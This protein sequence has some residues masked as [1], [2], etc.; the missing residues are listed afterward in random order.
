MYYKLV[1]SLLT[2]QEC[3]LVADI[4]LEK[5]DSGQWLTDSCELAKGFYSI[6]PDTIIDRLLP[7]VSDFAQ[8]KVNYNFDY[9]RIYPESQ[10]L[11]KHRD[12]TGCEYSV[13]VCIK[14]TTH[15][16][17]FWII[18]PESQKPESF[19]MLPGDGLIYRGTEVL[20]WREPNPH[21]DVFQAFIHFC[22]D[23]TFAEIV[24]YEPRHVRRKQQAEAIVTR[25]KLKAMF[26]RPVRK[27][28]SQKPDK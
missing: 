6:M 9:A 19:E 18:N 5:V 12:R 8:C 10:G 23:E 28:D 17:P 7:E 11:I 26:G 13:T 25:N 14:N 21:S 16:F 22:D 15:S 3:Q 4:M 27:Q 24:D 1:K 20:H 2:P